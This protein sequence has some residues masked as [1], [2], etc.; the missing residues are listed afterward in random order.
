MSTDSSNEA[1]VSA[2]LFAVASMPW[3]NEVIT[4]RSYADGEVFCSAFGNEHHV[5][6]NAAASALAL[7]KVNR[8]PVL[9]AGTASALHICTNLVQ[10]DD[11]ATIFRLRFPE[12]LG[13]VQSLHAS[14]LD[15]DGQQTLFVLSGHAHGGLCA[16]VGAKLYPVH[17][18]TG[19]G[20]KHCAFSAKQ[21][22]MMQEWSLPH[23]G[24]N[25][26]IVSIAVP[27]PNVVC[28]TQCDGT[29]RIGWLSMSRTS[30]FITI[31]QKSM[32]RLSL[33]LP[34]CHAQVTLIAENVLLWAACGKGGA[35]IVTIGADGGNKTDVR[36]LTTAST[37]LTRC[38]IVN[39]MSEVQLI[40]VDQFGHVYT[41]A[42]TLRGE[43]ARMRGGAH[44]NSW[45]PNRQIAPL[46]SQGVGLVAS[47]EQV[48]CYDFKNLMTLVPLGQP[49]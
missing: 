2:G 20:P 13:Y 28:V 22:R 4:A 40:A 25:N 48:I 32:F 29:A 39:T 46:A 49:S 34:V 8:V 7:A 36:Q 1:D 21:P 44:S 3:A 11:E 17:W 37:I 38:C 5:F 6:S 45:Q 16:V 12:S 15:I 26:P 47:P 19:N 43:D 9:V 42:L 35:S 23:S 41:R 27:Q 33:Q 14:V 30:Q 31:H 10:P 18:D 24:G